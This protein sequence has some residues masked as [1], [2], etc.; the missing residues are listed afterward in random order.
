MSYNDTSG[1]HAVPKTCVAKLDVFVVASV[2]LS[3]GTAVLIQWNP[4]TCTMY[5]IRTPQ[6]G[7]ILVNED[8]WAGMVPAT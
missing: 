3:S 2:V 1:I 7:S 6:K 8:T 4:S 5:S